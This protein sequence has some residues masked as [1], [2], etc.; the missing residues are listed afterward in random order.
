MAALKVE[1]TPLVVKAFTNSKVA[2]RSFFASNIQQ[3]IHFIDVA[4]VAP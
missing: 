2:C 3:M 1:T 4:V